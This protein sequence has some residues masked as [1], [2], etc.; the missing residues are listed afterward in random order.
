MS[1]TAPTIPRYPPKATALFTFFQRYVLGT[2]HT[3]ARSATSAQSNQTCCRSRKSY[4]TTTTK[5]NPQ[6]SRVTLINVEEPLHANRTPNQAILDWMHRRLQRKG[7]SKGSVGTLNSAIEELLQSIDYH[8]KLNKDVL[9]PPPD[10]WALYTALADSQLNL[11]SCP[12]DVYSAL[13]TYVIRTA[14]SPQ[15]CLDRIT[16]MITD[17]GYHRIVPLRSHWDLVLEAYEQWGKLWDVEAMLP[18]VERLSDL[19]NRGFVPKKAGISGKLYPRET[20]LYFTLLAKYA[21]RGNLLAVKRCA[22][23]IM[24]RFGPH[25]ETY[26]QVIAAYSVLDQPG[27]VYL[28]FQSLIEQGIAPTEKTIIWTLNSLARHRTISVSQ[29]INHTAGQTGERSDSQTSPVLPFLNTLK[30]VNHI[31]ASQPR[32]RINTLAAAFRVHTK[33]G[34]RKGA[35]ELLSKVTTQ[36]PDLRPDQRICLS[37]FSLYLRTHNLDAAHKLL[38]AMMTDCDIVPDTR[39]AYLHKVILQAYIISGHPILAYKH[40]LKMRSLSVRFNFAM[41]SMLITQLTKRHPDHALK[42]W[43]WMERDGVKPDVHV[44]SRMAA[45]LAPKQGDPNLRSV[46]TYRDAELES[47]IQPC[48]SLSIMADHK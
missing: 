23:T 44:R 40:A 15:S 32:A 46:A 7:S 8:S 37:F 43:K 45:L 47:Y 39:D 42:V 4:C 1:W 14:G 19:A 6:L 10:P 26:E 38:E 17:M 28:N 20:R 35:D 24:E 18:E 22:E 5:A 41:Y 11:E 3:R 36:I 27:I 21:K 31:L 34:D 25:P 48:Y 30:L 33:H 16:A 29:K 9:S 13:M 2:P 12:R